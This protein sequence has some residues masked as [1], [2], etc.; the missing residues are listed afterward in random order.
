MD[1]IP[2]TC[3]YTNWRVYYPQS[4]SKSITEER[5]QLTKPQEC[6]DNLGYRNESLQPRISRFFFSCCW[7]PIPTHFRRSSSIE[8]GGGSGGVTISS[9]RSVIHCWALFSG[10][11]YSILIHVSTE[12]QNPTHL[13]QSR[14]G[15]NSL[16]L[17]DL[18]SHRNRESGTL[19]FSANA[20]TWL[21]Y[22]IN[23]S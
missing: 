5:L 13:F 12:D 16:Q 15:I 9:H 21:L 22:F 18:L 1:N 8:G 3:H 20:R 6:I 4:N 23:V 10:T 2:C 17:A 14:H 11:G 19:S 7:I